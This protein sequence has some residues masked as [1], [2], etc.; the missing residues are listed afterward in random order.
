MNKTLLTLCLLA[1][2]V[3][4]S[5][6]QGGDPAARAEIEGLNKTVVK[7][8]GERKF[9][10][11]LEPA[12]RAQSLSEK[13]FGDRDELAAV[14][15]NNLAK[16]YAATGRAGDAEKLYRR[17]LSIYEKL[18]APDDLRGAPVLDSLGFLAMTVGQDPDRAAVLFKRA[19][20]IRVKALGG[21]HEE[22]L[23]TVGNLASAYS[24]RRDAARVEPLLK[25]V[26]EARERTLSAEDPKLLA[27]LQTYSCFLRQTG[28]GPEAAR[29]EERAFSAL[30]EQAGGGPIMVPSGLALCRVTA[31]QIPDF[32]SRLMSGV[33]RG[34]TVRVEV[35][36]DETGKV[37]SAKALDGPTD[38]RASTTQAASRTRFAPLLLKGKAVVFST[39][40]TY[41]QGPVG[42]VEDAGGVV[43]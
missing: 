27:A 9:E 1:C 37:V 30:A 29:V 39:V 31:M 2:L 22:V 19:L 3:A 28:R 7:L 16:V 11:A 12:K 33:T 35:V 18:F 38:L 14:S 20:E 10:E 4:Q 21:E 34:G 24:A 13:T 8:F 36:V 17:A 32:T 23:L 6:A 15:L 40:L 41:T 43:R 42:R 26:V 25:Y 5:R